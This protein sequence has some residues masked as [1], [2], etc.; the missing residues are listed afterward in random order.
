[1]HAI[2]KED[3]K[4]FTPDASSVCRIPDGNSNRYLRETRKIEE[5][6]RGIEPKY[7]EAVANFTRKVFDPTSIYVLAGY[8]AYV[9]SCS[10]AAMR[11]Q[12]PIISSLVEETH[13]RHDASAAIP[14]PPPDLAGASLTEQLNDRDLE[15][16]TDPKFPQA[17][18]IASILQNTIGLGNFSW[19][20]L[21]NT[22]GD[23]P[24]FTSDYPVAIEKA[25]DFQMI[26]RI[27]PLS[28]GVAVRLRPQTVENEALQNYKFSR[29]RGRVLHLSRQEAIW[30]NRS[31]VRSAES[32]VFY[33][34]PLAW[35][36]KFVAKN[37]KY[38][39]EPKT[40]RITERGSTLLWT[41]QAIR[42]IRPIL[43]NNQLRS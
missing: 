5:F 37:A 40:L 22:F 2:R 31:L 9:I 3:L 26:D 8:A 6:L 21:I 17:F 34:D 30:I 10:P 19:D 27:L 11:L 13:K 38:R 43:K 4:G 18:S 24:F 29:F 15:V 7:N 14:V 42:K 12:S 28:P 33:R 25:G 16:H 32:M 41:T 1:M 36:P 39:I 23:S 35:I 20:V